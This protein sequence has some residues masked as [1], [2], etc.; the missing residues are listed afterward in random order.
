MIFV[1]LLSVGRAQ[2]RPHLRVLEHVL[3]QP[4]VVTG[5]HPGEPAILKRQV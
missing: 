1:H 2:N 5:A 4:V 3:L